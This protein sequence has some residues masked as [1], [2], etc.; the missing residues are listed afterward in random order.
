MVWMPCPPRSP[1][2]PLPVEIDMNRTIAREMVKAGVCRVLRD[3]A[4]GCRLPAARR[5]T[6]ALA[7]AIERI[8][9]VAPPPNP[10]P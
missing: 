8:A 2:G 9:R 5:A 10:E 6:R 4:N 7:T 1:D 3:Q